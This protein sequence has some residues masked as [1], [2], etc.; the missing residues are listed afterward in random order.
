MEDLLEEISYSNSEE[1]KISY[2]NKKQSDV[3]K[4][5]LRETYKNLNE[6]RLRE[7]T[8]EAV[9]APDN[10]AIN[11]DGRNLTASQLRYE[12]ACSIEETA[13]QR[14]LRTIEPDMQA[15]MAES[16]EEINSGTNSEDEYFRW[17]NYTTDILKNMNDGFVTEED[18][19]MREEFIEI[20]E[21]RETELMLC[22]G[23]LMGSSNH[24][25]ENKAK[26]LRYKLQ[27]LREMKSAIE[28]TTRSQADVEISRAEYERAIP[29]YKLFKTLQKLPFGYDVNR[30]QKIA[31]G[32][33]HDEDEEFEYEY[34]FY[35]KMLENA[36]DEM[37]E[38]DDVY[39]VSRNYQLA[40]DMAHER[41]MNFSN[42]ISDKLQ[43]LTGR[44][45]SFKL[46]Y[47]SLDSENK[48]N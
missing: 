43:K 33:D 37:K 40:Y 5:A 28:I 9:F 27:K 26:T 7:L 11:I 4:Q 48:L 38:E 1:N 10:R 45:N 14:T 3:I 12:L 34:S 13:C 8:R 23:L 41:N 39:I 35:D 6:K 44:R 18:F 46:K 16:I 15:Q 29:Y 24:Q 36:L 31:L 47:E 20:A 30:E 2:E 19:D 42:E 25:S 17:L 22:L 32:I 21:Q